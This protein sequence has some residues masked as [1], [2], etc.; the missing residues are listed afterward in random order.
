MAK[1]PP[2]YIAVGE[3]EIFYDEGLLIAQRIKDSAPN[4]VVELEVSTGQFHDFSLFVD[5]IPEAVESMAAI[6]KFINKE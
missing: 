5:W 4:K 6:K 2:I 1:L 3:N